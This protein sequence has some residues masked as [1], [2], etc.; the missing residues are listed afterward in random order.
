MVP[1]STLMY[2]SSLR[3]ETRT[4]RA[5]STWPREA[6]VMPLPT[7]EMTPPVTKMYLVSL[8]RPPRESSGFQHHHRRF[9][10]Q[11]G[12]GDHQPWL[13]CDV[14]LAH[15]MAEALDWRAGHS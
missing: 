7:E 3:I 1:G 8:M 2:G 11:R 4:P 10:R 5:L 13:R 6:T 14:R 9:G 15:L 12:L